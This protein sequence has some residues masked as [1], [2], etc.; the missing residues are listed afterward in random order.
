VRERQRCR[1]CLLRFYITGFVQG[2]LAHTYM[3][4]R[5]CFPDNLTG[6]EATAVFVRKLREIA[7]ASNRLGKPPPEAEKFF[8]SPLNVSVAA[9]L[10]LQFKCR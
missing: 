9:A 5:L 4:D 6:E 8:S 10:G 7:E 1:A 3:S 2:V